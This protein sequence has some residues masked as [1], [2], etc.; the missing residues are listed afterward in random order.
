M[1]LI[2]I[3]EAAFMGTSV[4]FSS[5]EAQWSLSIRGIDGKNDRRF[6]DFHDKP[7]TAGDVLRFL[8]H[9]QD[10]MWQHIPDSMFST[11]VSRAISSTRAEEHACEIELSATRNSAL[12]HKEI[13]A[14]FEAF[15]ALPG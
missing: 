8:P 15:M 14:E 11:S 9:W 1:A 2:F 10:L 5:R 3:G 6:L 12:S 7:A 4:E 13:I